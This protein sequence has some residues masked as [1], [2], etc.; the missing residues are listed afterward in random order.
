MGPVFSSPDAAWKPSVE[1]ADAQTRIETV[2]WR[3]KQ[4]PGDAV[5]LLVN[6]SERPAKIKITAK[7]LAG[8]EVHCW[9]ELQTI[10]TDANGTWLDRVGPLGVRIYSVAAPPTG[11]E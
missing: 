4:M 10:K 7:P 8:R 5:I 3:V 9:G 2:E 1:A 11:I 6:G